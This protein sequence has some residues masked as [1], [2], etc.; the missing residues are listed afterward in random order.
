VCEYTFYVLIERPVHTDL[1]LDNGRR[2]LT[3]GLPTFI[4]RYVLINA[5]GNMRKMMRDDFEQYLAKQEEF[6]NPAGLGDV[7]D[8]LKRPKGEA[9]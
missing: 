2:Q 6:G 3:C 1:T 9:A 4:Q 8:V 5:D 7:H